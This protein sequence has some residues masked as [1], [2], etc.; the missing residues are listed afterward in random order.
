[1]AL[2]LMI[3]KL[4]FF[5]LQPGP[6]PIVSMGP[7]CGKLQRLM[8]CLMWEANM[9]LT[10]LSL[11]ILSPIATNQEDVLV[12]LRFAE[13]RDVTDINRATV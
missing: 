1:M 7:S 3:L 9:R 5:R 4:I 2:S 11:L 6:Q 13:L 8:Q 12:R 10:G